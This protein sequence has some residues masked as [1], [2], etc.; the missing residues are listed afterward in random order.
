[1]QYNIKLDLSLDTTALSQLLGTLDNG[2]HRLMRPIIDTIINQAQAQDMAA[3]APAQAVPPPET[4]A[5]ETE[6]VGGTD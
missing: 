3:Q 6:P 2:P 4:A 1:M 5:S